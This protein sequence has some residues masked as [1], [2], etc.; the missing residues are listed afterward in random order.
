MV[1]PVVPVLILDF[2]D[3]FPANRQLRNDLVANTERLF[4]NC[5]VFIVSLTFNLT[6]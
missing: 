4:E 2:M 5:F 6:W 3:Q 1:T